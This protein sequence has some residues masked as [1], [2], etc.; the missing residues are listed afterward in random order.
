MEK[1]KDHW[2][3][4]RYKCSNCGQSLFDS[5]SKFNSGTP[6]ASFR[7]AAA[8]AI[9]TQPDHSHGMVRTELLCSQCQQH[10]GHVFDDGQLCGDTHPEAGQRFCILSEALE[11]EHESQ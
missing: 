4:G 7:K 1:Y 9:N 2:Q 11:F 8:G 5:E 10:L 6:W 3:K